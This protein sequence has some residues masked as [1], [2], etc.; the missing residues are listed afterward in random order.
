MGLH[1]DLKDADPGTRTA[2]LAIAATKKEQTADGVGLA[3]WLKLSELMCWD[4]ALLCASAANGIHSS[5]VNLSAKD[6]HLVEAEQYSAIFPKDSRTTQWVDS[7]TQLLSL[8]VVG[9]VGFVDQNP[10]NKLRHVMIYT[11]EGMGCGNKNSCV[12]RRGLDV[13]WQHLSLTEFW[14]DVDFGGSA[15]TRMIYSPIVGQ[16]IT[17]PAGDSHHPATST[18]RSSSPAATSLTGQD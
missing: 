7:R 16:T 12:L 11:G 13:G 10:A 9:F 14:T 15:H 3:L 8:P 2:N 1:V 5:S 17:S 6:F 4:A 18:R